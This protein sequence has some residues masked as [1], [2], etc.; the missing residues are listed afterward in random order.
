MRSAIRD[1]L[2]ELEQQR[3]SESS[4]EH[5]RARPLDERMLAVGPETGL[6]LNTLAR[7]TGAQAV[8]SG[9]ELA[10]YQTDGEPADWEPWLCEP[11]RVA[12]AEGDPQT[13]PTL[14]SIGLQRTGAGLQVTLNEVDNALSFAVG[15]RGWT[16]STPADT[17]GKGIPVAAAGGW[18]DQ[19][20]LRLEVI[21]LET[22]HRMDVVC[23]LDD[24]CASA[25]WRLP[26]L[27]GFHL[28][29]LRN[30]I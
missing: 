18:S 8:V 27:G 11:F 15:T 9:L 17:F 12:S 5:G 19:K 28:Q 3:L 1:T 22:P 6:F 7:A 24:R 13:Q 14:T 4:G 16:V 10:A 25:A 26:P 20:T 2:D 23:S 29:D 30:P 21:L